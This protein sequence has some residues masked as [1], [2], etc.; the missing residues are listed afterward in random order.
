MR[1]VVTA[2]ASAVLNPMCAVTAKRQT[3]APDLLSQCPAAVR[4]QGFVQTYFSLKN[5]FS[6]VPGFLFNEQVGVVGR[7]C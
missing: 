7:S 2:F 1:S 5:M 6:V 3:S 4:F